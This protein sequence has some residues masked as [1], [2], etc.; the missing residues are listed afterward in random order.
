MGYHNTKIERGILGEYS[1]IREEFDELTDAVQQDCKGL[2]ICELCDMIG[3][4]EEYIK[5]YNLTIDDLKQF[6]DLTK[7]SFKDGSRK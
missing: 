6:S 2:I 7:R 5:K 3:A 4:I 1:K